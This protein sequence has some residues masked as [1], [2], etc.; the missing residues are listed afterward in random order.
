MNE[1]FKTVLP[2][3]KGFL[4]WQFG[5][6]G[7][8]EISTIVES[9]YTDTLGYHGERGTEGSEKLHEL[10]SERMTSEIESMKAQLAPPKYQLD[11]M[12]SVL[13]VCGR[14]I[15]LV[16]NSS[17][18]ISFRLTSCG[19]SL[20]CLIYLLLQRHKKIMDLAQT[21]V[22]DEEEFWTM[23]ESIWNVREAFDKRYR[24]LV[25]GWRQQ[26]LDISMQ[27]QSFASG[28]FEGWHADYDDVSTNYRLLWL[29]RLTKITSIV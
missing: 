1:S 23:G 4:E 16:S 28:M 27:V 13:A 5:E 11:D 2:Q 17:R 10:R 9:I 20:P 15:E 29:Q 22:L 18:T 14:Q 26:R 7:L 8:P 24:D 6:E 19:K 3:N 12:A 21:Y 25:E